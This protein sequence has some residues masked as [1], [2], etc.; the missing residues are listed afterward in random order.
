M[1]DLVCADVSYCDKHALFRRTRTRVL[2]SGTMPIVIKDDPVLVDLGFVEVP[3]LLVILV[4]AA[5]YR[6]LYY[7]C[8]AHGNEWFGKAYAKLDTYG[9]VEW[10]SRYDTSP[11]FR[12]CSNW[13][14][15][16][17]LPSQNCKQCERDSVC[18]LWSVGHP[19]CVLCWKRGWLDA[20]GTTA[21][22]VCILWN[23]VSLG[24][25]LA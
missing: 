8:E 4:S 6:M 2:P 17:P 18:L 5:L 15:C 10:N 3:F 20:Q 7:A 14:S 25:L 12:W 9:R 11:V 13:H 21:R 19:R 22:S 24:H 23:C 1:R 16:I